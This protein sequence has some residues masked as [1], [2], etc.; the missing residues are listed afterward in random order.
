[1]EYGIEQ[2]RRLWQAR[3]GIG[4]HWNGTEVDYV[5]QLDGTAGEVWRVL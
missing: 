5:K 1:M 3:Q 4:G 2:A